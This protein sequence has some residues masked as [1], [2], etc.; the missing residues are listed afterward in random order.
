M[1]VGQRIDGK[2]PNIYRFSTILKIGGLSDFAGS[3]TWYPNGCTAGCSATFPSCVR[4]VETE[5]VSSEK[6]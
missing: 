3:S 4:L 1:L 6:Y 2:H 5:P